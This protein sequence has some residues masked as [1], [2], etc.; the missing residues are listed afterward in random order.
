MHDDNTILMAALESAVSAFR[1]ANPNP[2]LLG[3]TPDRSVLGPLAAAIERC[4]AYRAVAGQVVFSGGS[5]PILNSG[6]LASQLFS[7][8]G[9]PTKDVGGAVNWLLKLLQTRQATVLVKAAIWGLRVNQPLALSQTAQVVPF[10]ALPDSYM[11]KRLEDHARRC[12]DE[13]AW[14]APNYYDLPDAAY[15]EEV[16]H[17]P[18]IRPDGASFQRMAELER[19]VDDL[20]TILQATIVG[21]PIAVACW[22]EYLDSDLEYSTWENAFAWLLPEVHPR[23]QRGSL[24]EES[25][26][27][28]NVSSFDALSGIKD[29]RE[30]LLRSMNRFRLSQ[31][32]R[33]PIDRVLDLALAFE[34]AVSDQSSGEH[35]PPSWKVSVRTAQIV[36]GAL[37]ER[38]Q[39]RKSISELYTLRNRATHG[40]HLRGKSAANPDLVIETSC[41]IYVRLMTKLLSIKEGPDWN[42]VELSGMP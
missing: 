22:F 19:R 7:R 39:N 18:F 30:T 17:F 9:W 1:K 13:S 8:G 25:I 26:I 5:G 20:A 6:S 29:R 31:S 3:S 42:A 37:S 24:V 38:Q 10:A 35:I 27:Q 4:A 36:G 2:T 21:R 34:I 11:K 33:Q 16:S 28:D 40:G 23:V 41:A 15:V 14:V 12:Y 32:R